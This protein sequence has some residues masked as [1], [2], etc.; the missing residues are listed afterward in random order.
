MG[1]G[2]RRWVGKEGKKGEMGRKKGRR[3]GWVGKREGEGRWANKDCALTLKLKAD[4]IR[5]STCGEISRR[6]PSRVHNRVTLFCKK[7]ESETD[8][9]IFPLHPT[10]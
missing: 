6:S 5:K 2:K 10:T 7:F 9:V 1:E 8:N 4:H 3:E